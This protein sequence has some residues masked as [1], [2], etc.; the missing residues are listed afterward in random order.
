MTNISKIFDLLRVS[1]QQVVRHRKRYLGVVLAISFGTC[2]L[3]L[4]LTAGRD[5]KQNLNRDLDLLGGA[6]RV[7]VCL[8]EN[9]SSLDRIPKPQW[10]RQETIDAVRTLA[11]VRDVSV[12]SVK[13][14]P[15]V[16]IVRGHEH[17][18][19]LFGVDGPFWEVNSFS[20]ANGEFFGP[21]AVKKHLRVCV[22]GVE[23]A[24]QIFGRV[25]ATGLTL[26]IDSE[27]FVVTGVLG[28]TGIGDRANYAFIPLT[29]AQDRIQGFSFPDRIYI[30]CQSWDD[31]GPVATVVPKTIQNYQPGDRFALEVAWE[32]LK[33]VKRIAWWMETFIYLSIAATLVLGGM[34]I[35]NGMM[36]TVQTRTR[37]I[38]L[39]KAIG[40]EDRDILIQFLGEALFLSF[41]STI[42]GVVLGRGAI[43]VV[44]RILNS[45]PSEDL[46]V[47]SVVL[48]IVFSLLLGVGAGFTPSMLASRMEVVSALRY[49]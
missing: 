18:F 3:I 12:V 15:A 47:L 40:A 42:V 38:G 48:S 8:E 21:D 46:F 36:A 24:Q 30:R 49:E 9:Q 45:H 43:M 6:T 34:G 33:R 26:P 35:W 44:S 20:P 1:I 2:G 37:E 23:L 41:G 16:S 19:T 11:G 4:V 22:L 27:L 29:T 32:Q 14:G 28:G 25:D 5:V 13:P 7:R 31:V 17:R 39:K 10:F